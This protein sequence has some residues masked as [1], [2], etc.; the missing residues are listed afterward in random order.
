MNTY[1]FDFDG[2][3]V[4]SM[5]NYCKVMTGLLDKYNIPYD[6]TLIKYI[7]PLGFTRT[8]AYFKELGLPLSIE[9]IASSAMQNLLYEYTNTIPAKPHVLEV[10]NTLKSRGASLNILTA[11][12]HP[13]L[14]PCSK[15]LGLWDLCDNVWSC[16][17]FG[18][19][20]TEPEIYKK[21]AKRLGV[22]PE[23][24]IFMDDNC[25]ADRAAKTAGMYVIG[26]YDESSADYVDEMKKI[27][28]RYIYDFSELLSI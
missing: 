22:A 10:M 28:D 3:L 16:D 1:I 7:T 23:K 21:A 25:N 17:D 6:D 2:T 4:D 11:G 14:D 5:P 18:M 19:S 13:A 12:V 27:C 8:I 15:R 9:E 26:I 24:V 20:K